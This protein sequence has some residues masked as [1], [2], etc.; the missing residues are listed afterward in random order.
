MGLSTAVMALRVMALSARRNWVVSRAWACLTSAHW[1]CG[2]QTALSCIPLWL[3]LTASRQGIASKWGSLK[4]ADLRRF[5]MSKFTSRSYLQMLHTRHL[6][7]YVNYSYKC[8]THACIWL[9]VCSTCKYACICM[10]IHACLHTQTCSHTDACPLLQT[11]AYKHTHSQS[12]S[13]THTH[14]QIQ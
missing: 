6:S 7:P 4:P 3:F 11:Q 8:Y 13:H 10:Y 2:Q 5:L 1:S 9:T 12:L 14:T